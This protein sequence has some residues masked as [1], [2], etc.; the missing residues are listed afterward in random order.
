MDLDKI[1]DHAALTMRF[2]RANFV[3][4]DGRTLHGGRLSRVGISVGGGLGKPRSGLAVFAGL[5]MDLAGVAWKNSGQGDPADFGTN[6]GDGI[7]YLGLAAHGF[8][9]T[10]GARIRSKLS[11]LDINDQFTTGMDT[12]IYRQGTPAGVRDTTR[13]SQEKEIQRGYVFNLYHAEGVSLGAVVEQFKSAVE[14]GAQ[15]ET[16]RFTALRGLIQPEELMKR[17]DLRQLGV[18]SLG[19]DRFAAGVDYYGDTY[20]DIRRAAEQGTA[21]PAASTKSM[22]ELPIGVYDIAAL[23]FR[24]VFTPELYPNPRFRSLEVGWTFRSPNYTELHINFDLGARGFAFYR[25][26][27][28]T[29]GGEGFVAGGVGK[30]HF[31]FS[32]SYNAPGSSNFF[33]IPDTVVYG[34]QAIIGP[35]DMARPL[36]PMIGQA[37]D[38]R[39]RGAEGK[40][41][42]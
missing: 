30:Y 6:A 39:R 31:A 28:Y 25:G 2:T 35:V 42:E 4:N 8:A 18:P 19:L 27:G 34:V 16:T 10:G 26:D 7:G 15:Q 14:S 41:A 33:P 38:A 23:G 40:E 9:L 22:Y 1:E 12:P 24:A 37:R 5:T 20:K 21:L 36:I 32:A 3:L 29:G 17:I 13:D 11:Q